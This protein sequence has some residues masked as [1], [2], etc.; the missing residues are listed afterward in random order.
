MSLQVD[1]VFS[2]SFLW[3]HHL[4]VSSAR[5]FRDY[6]IIELSTDTGL[7]WMSFGWHSGLSA[8]WN[9]NLNGYPGSTLWG[10]MY[11]SYGSA[12]SAATET[13]AYRQIDMVKGHSGS[14]VYLYDG[15]SSR[16]IYGVNNVQYWSSGDAKPST[17]NYGSGHT[18]PSWNQAVRIT[19]YKFTN[20]CGWINDFAALGC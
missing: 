14:G 2:L 13:F 3:S 5:S 9:F 10:R 20:I 18:S 19:S 12:L 4:F 7:G 6:A 16:I 11:H 17:D 1:G 15:G 8:G